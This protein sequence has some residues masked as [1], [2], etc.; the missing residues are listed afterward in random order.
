MR[1]GPTLKRVDPRT[2]GAQGRPAPDS[3]LVAARA[4]GRRSLVQR[5]RKHRQPNVVVRRG[6]LTAHP[7]EEAGEWLSD[8]ATM[9]QNRN[10]FD[11]YHAP[12]YF[13]CN[14]SRQQPTMAA[15]SGRIQGDEMDGYSTSWS[16]DS[17]FF[18]G[19][20]HNI[21]TAPEASRCEPRDRRTVR[22]A[23][24][25]STAVRARIA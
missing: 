3:P 21:F 10:G 25:R 9:L 18:S 7:Q 6:N 12:R 20:I 14:P 5:W 15:S 24:G 1:S 4:A 2:T 23:H 11:P 13:A 17:G 8:P 22:P 19:G 16:P